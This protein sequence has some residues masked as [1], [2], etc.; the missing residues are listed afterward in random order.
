MSI[1]I[2]NFDYNKVRLQIRAIENGVNKLYTTEAYGNRYYF[3]LLNEPVPSME[4]ATFQSFLTFTQ[5]GTA[6]HTYTL[7]PLLPAETV[8]IET[9]VVGI[10]ANASKGYVMKSFGGFRHNGTGIFRIGSSIDYDTKTDF[11]S[12]SA[13]FMISG[14][15][16]ICLCVT[17]QTNEVIDWDIHVNYTKGFHAISGAPEDVCNTFSCKP[18]FPSFDEPITPPLIE[19]PNEPLQ[20]A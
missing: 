18:I 17:G 8:M 3:T 10:N 16:S 2:K 6:S 4:S 12:A 15:Q 11:T 5:S 1:L 19:D 14:S 13:S 7:I 9:K 20:P